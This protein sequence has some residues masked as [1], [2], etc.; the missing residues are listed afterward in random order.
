MHNAD[1]KK[2]ITVPLKHYDH[3]LNVRNGE[4]CLYLY[5]LLEL[6]SVALDGQN[7]HNVPARHN[8]FD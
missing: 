4:M 8:S 1:G 7:P 5:I 6:L 3:G 2:T